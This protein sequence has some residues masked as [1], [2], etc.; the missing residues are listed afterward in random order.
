MK[1]IYILILALLSMGSLSAQHNVTFQVDMNGVTASPA[2]VHVAGSFQAAAGNPNGDWDPNGTM[3]TDG[4]SD[5]IYDVTVSIPTGYYEFKFINDT[6]WGSEETVAAVATV[7][8]GT[9]N[10][11]RYFWVHSDTTLAAVT[12]GGAAPTGLN[13]VKLKADMRNHLQPNHLVNAMGS[14]DGYSVPV[15]MYDPD[16]DSIFTNYTYAM[17]GQI[18]Y[19]FRD[20]L[21]WGT[22]ESVTDTVCGGAGGFG[23]DRKLDVTADVIEGPHCY[24][25]CGPCVAGPVLDTIDVTFQ[26]DMS[27]AC[28]A[29]DSVAI[30]G[31]FNGW[32]SPG[33]QLSDPDNDGIWTVTLQIANNTN[34]EYK[35]QNLVGGNTNW[36]GVANRQFNTTATTAQTVPVV[37]FNETGPCGPVPAP[38]D[39]TFSV[40]MSQSVPADTI[41]VM[42]NFT[43]PNWQSGA[44]PLSLVDPAG[45][46][47]TTV[48]VC[49]ATFQ[50]KYVNGDPND[51][52]NEEFDGDTAVACAVSNGIGGWNREVTR[53]SSNDTTLPI[54]IF[55][56]C[57]VSTVS[58]PELSSGPQ[59][60]VYPNP[61]EDFTTVEFTSVGRHDLVLMD[62]TG[63]LVKQEL[64]FTGSRVVITGGELQSGIYFL[65]VANDRGEKKV[66]KL[67]V[68]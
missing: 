34:W 48:E 59:F 25:A 27:N 17:A 65:S 12:F 28:P 16:G 10:S 44:L 53:T 60:A 18:T 23:N 37:C 43:T 61:F 55:S 39:V 63:K 7:D 31:A 11:N 14:W 19:K 13:F 20:T 33:T 41:W 66:T 6:A 38:A 9:G 22:A 67:I 51:Q 5:G 24:G 68:R 32:P 42:G 4:N 2:G 49:P 8:E 56:S 45:I 64:G 62:V 36:E 29:P 47:A 54:F 50:Y 26:V 30:A 1:K 57:D 52:S 3:L 35:F 15:R 58:V 40:D 46:F 21:D